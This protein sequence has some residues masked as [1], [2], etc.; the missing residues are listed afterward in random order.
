MGNQLIVNEK[1]ADVMGWKV[2]DSV[3]AV[4]DDKQGSMTIGAIT[5]NY[6][7]NYI[8]LLPESYESLFGQ[9]V[10]Y[11][12]VL[13]NMND[14]T[15]ESRLATDLLENENILGVISPKLTPC[16]GQA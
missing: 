15:Q 5:E 3:S 14:S 11:N 1:L 2:G 10:D 16:S 13:M 12:T 7:L 4:Y 8:Y 9:A 6:T